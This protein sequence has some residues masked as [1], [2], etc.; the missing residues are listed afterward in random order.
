MSMG[1]LTILHDF[2][3]VGKKV[4]RWIEKYTGLRNMVVV[5][6]QWNI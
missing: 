6:V 3:Q 2:R 1:S 4:H 5:D